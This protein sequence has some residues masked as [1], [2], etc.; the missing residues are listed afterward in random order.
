MKAGFVI[1]ILPYSFALILFYALAIHMHQSL[2]DGLK[3]LERTG[4]LQHCLCMI[5][6]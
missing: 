3:E 2:M 4:L 6:F 1:S 5:K